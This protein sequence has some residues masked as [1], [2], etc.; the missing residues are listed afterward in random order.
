MG[1]GFWLGA[2][3]GLVLA[4]IVIYAAAMARDYW[5]EITGMARKIVRRN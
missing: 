4:I 5:P 2:N 1:N 3:A